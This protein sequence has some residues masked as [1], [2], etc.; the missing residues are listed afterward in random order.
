MSDEEGYKEE[1][2][3]GGILPEEDV[4]TSVFVTRIPWSWQKENVSK[5]F[6]EEFGNVTEVTLKWD[7]RNDRHRGMGFVTFEDKSTKG[8]AIKK[9]KLK[10]VKWKHKATGTLKIYEPDLSV[11]ENSS[12]TCF[13][14]NSGRCARGDSCSYWHDP[15]ITQTTSSTETS[16]KQKKCWKFMKGKCKAGDAC[17][18]RHVAKTAAEETMK[19]ERVRVCLSWK[20]KGRCGKQDKCAFAHPAEVAE[21]LRAKKERKKL[22]AASK[23]GKNKNGTDTEKVGTGACVRVLG[24]PY[25]TEE[26]AIREL[27][28][29]CGTIQSIDMPFFEDSGRS[30]G[31]CSIIFAAQAEATAAISKNGE[32]VGDRWIKVEQGDMRRSWQALGRKK[33]KDCNAVFVGNLS[34]EATQED[35]AGAFRLCGAVKEIRLHA[36]KAY[37]FVQFKKNTAPAKAVELNG[38]KLLGRPMRI[39]FAESNS[40]KKERITVEKKKGGR[41]KKRQK[42]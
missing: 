3:R 24:F 20:R 6:N 7:E 35:L 16:K 33:P 31:F 42:T 15:D 10:L 29:E 11:G 19:T 23:K 9:G 18:L 28:S 4:E 40:E 17:L 37:A 25:E 34:Y 26:S 30:K 32:K 41:P 8:E 21:K 22:E 36:N 38:T 5:I 27:F 1:T 13:D 39:D 12:K 2:R 14:W